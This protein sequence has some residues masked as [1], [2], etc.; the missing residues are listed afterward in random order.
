MDQTVHPLVTLGALGEAAV[1]EFAAEIEGE[2]H[3]P[4]GEGYDDARRVWNGLV[5]EYPALIVRVAGPADVARALGFARE[6]DLSLS[7]RSG[8]HGQA[9]DAVASNGLV[10]DLGGLDRVEVDPEARVVTVGPGAS[11]ADLL[12]ATTE[13]GLATP[14]GSAGSPGVGGTTLHG[15]IGWLRGEHGLSVDAVRRL[16]V[17]TPDGERRTATPEREPD[18]FWALRG[19]SGGVGVVTELEF[20]LHE[21]GR[22]GLVAG[23]SVFYP[24]ADADA[25]VE[26]FRAFHDDGPAAATVICN[27]GEVPPLPGMP[28]E[29]HGEPAVGLIGCHTGPDPEAAMAELAPLRAAAEPLVDRS[30]PMPYAALHEIGTLLHPSGRKYSHRSAFVDGLTD[31]VHELALERTAAAPGP[32][33]GVGVWPLGDAVGSGPPS[34]VP[35][36]DREHLVV[37]EA[38]WEGHDSPAHLEWARETERLLREAGA[39]GAYAGYAGADEPAPPETVYGEH[40]DRLA[41]LERRYDPANLLGRRAADGA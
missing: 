14:T 25:V 37:V 20:E 26:R 17:V 4:D 32:A 27:Y 6:H 35:W 9:G 22:D 23:L 8:G 21:V 39:T 38:A 29:H 11:T 36:T 16:E 31:D 7:V 18:L 33:D 34:A 19:G 12:A 3:T 5:N 1:G 30:E 2:L 10:V 28:P 13:H 40:R 15:G 24:R 41:E